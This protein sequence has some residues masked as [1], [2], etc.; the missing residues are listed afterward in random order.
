MRHF[1]SLR[2]LWIVAALFV[3]GCGDGSV[4]TVEVSGEV[5]V[6]GQPMEGVE[7]HF[8]H[9]QHKG[10][11]LTDAQGKYTL[12]GGAAIGDNKIYFSKIEGFSTDP[13]SGMDAGQAMAAAA[14]GADPNTGIAPPPKGQLIPLKYASYETTDKTFNV[15]A[16]GAKDV[17]FDLAP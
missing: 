3:V 8:V 9:P 6:G 12:R 5:K 15:P 7:V 13:A 17:N 2:S 1:I 16:D 10:F 14:A 4:P 11:G